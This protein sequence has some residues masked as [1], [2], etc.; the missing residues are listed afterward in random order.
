MK[1]SASIELSWQL[2]GREAIAGEFGQIEPEHF[3]AAVLKLAEL[4]VEDVGNFAPGANVARELAAEVNTIR[5][6]LESRSI[7]SIRVRRALRARLGKGGAP[8]DGGENHRSQASKDLCRGFRNLMIVCWR[9]LS[10]SVFVLLAFACRDGIPRR[11]RWHTARLR[12]VRV[13][14]SGPR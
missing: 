12:L 13:L 6:E 7:D 4:P 9:Q 10:T 5:Q 14:S 8:Y 11:N 2:A 3:F 1:V